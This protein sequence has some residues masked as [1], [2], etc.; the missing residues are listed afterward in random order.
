MKDLE[1]E[2]VV[3]VHLHV[4]D[5]GGATIADRLPVECVFLRRAAMDAYREAHP[6]YSRIILRMLVRV[7]RLE[8]DPE[9]AV[10]REVPMLGLRRVGS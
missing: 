5:E 1:L 3:F 7:N 2:R 10:L 8:G 9:Q 6:M 4:L